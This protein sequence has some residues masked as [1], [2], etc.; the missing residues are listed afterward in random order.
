MGTT[1]TSYDECAELCVNEPDDPKFCEVND[2]LYAAY[3]TLECT[4]VRNECEAGCL[5][6]SDVAD[7]QREYPDYATL[8]ATLVGETDDAIEN[9]CARDPCPS[10]TRDPDAPTTTTT[11]RDPD[12]PT[13]TLD[14]DADDSYLRFDCPDEEGEGCSIHV[15]LTLDVCLLNFKFGRRQMYDLIKQPFTYV[16]E[17]ELSDYL[18]FCSE[19]ELRIETYIVDFANDAAMQRGKRSPTRMEDCESATEVCGDARNEFGVS[20]GVSVGLFCGE[21]TTLKA[22]YRALLALLDAG[23]FD[24]SYVDRCLGLSIESDS[25]CLDGFGGVEIAE[26]RMVMADEDGNEIPETEVN[27]SGAPIKSLVM[28]AF[29]VVLCMW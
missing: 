10:T 1:T 26:A 9:F 28:M 16:I 4:R 19:S 18:D 12:E 8:I 23:T 17:T 22:M 11:T 2:P 3:F 21:C 14:C 27:T 15:D 7:A 25:I 13:T 24:V 6:E 5:I 20:V 29:A